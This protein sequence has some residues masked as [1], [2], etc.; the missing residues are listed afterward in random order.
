MS[1]K[2]QR[3]CLKSNS[4]A[5]YSDSDSY[6]TYYGVYAINGQTNSLVIEAS[7]GL[8]MDPDPYS[9]STGLLLRL[10]SRQ[11]LQAEVQSTP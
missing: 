1:L 11:H 9:N 4:L 10:Q 5:D 3:D 7:G 2:H 6:S 8:I